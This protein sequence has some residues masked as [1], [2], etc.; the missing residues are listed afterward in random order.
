LKHE[1]LGNTSPLEYSDVGS[2]GSSVFA[3]FTN[4]SNTDRPTHRPR[5]ICSNRPHL[6][7]QHSTIVNIGIH[8]TML[9]LLLLLLRRQLRRRRRRLLLL[10]HPFN[11][12]FSRTTRVSRYQNGDTSL[13]L[14]RQ[15]TMRFWDGI[16]ISWTTCKQSA[17]RCRQITA[18]TPHRSC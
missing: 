3:G 2:I 12:L 5:Y 16:G 11:G 8:P 18:A 13:D 7:L 1:K 4:M 14:M 10:L 9:L 15:E 6:M 17:P